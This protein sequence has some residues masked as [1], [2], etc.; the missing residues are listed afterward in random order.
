MYRSLA[1]SGVQRMT[2]RPRT[3]AAL[4]SGLQFIGIGTAAGALLGLAGSGVLDLYVCMLCT[5]EGAIVGFLIVTPI[6][7]FEVLVMQGRPGE[8]I[9]RLPFVAVMGIRKL[10]YLTS[11]L[12]G[13]SIG[14][15][16][17]DAGGI[18]FSTERFA[19]DAAIAFLGAFALVFYIQVNRMLG[20]GVL[21]KFVSGRY[22]RPREE[23]RVFLFVDLVSSTRIAESIGN[24]RFHELLNAITFELADPVLEHRGE[25]YRYVGDQI[26][27]T[28]P[29][30][31][32]LRDGAA[33][34]CCFAILDKMA[35]LEPDYHRRFGVAPRFHAALH[36]GPVVSGEMGDVRREIVYL[37]DVLNT[38]AR[39]EE[40]CR[41]MRHPV[42]A[43]KALLDRLRLPAGIAARSIGS[44]QLR[45]KEREV[46]LHA[47]SRDTALAAAAE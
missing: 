18:G 5:L 39:M 35:S 22:Q 43:S 21:A 6:V 34:R 20:G 29:A 17:W 40:A 46:G 13:L 36:C 11:I 44:I 19:S 23:E 31:A 25:I 12:V 14:R 4:R 37:G 7:L 1:A 41:E 10:V 26:I 45:G 8:R 32:G 9:L 28:W 42:I 33:V 15:I 38:T 16:V 24:V 27:I 30:A 2:V 3:H 47:L